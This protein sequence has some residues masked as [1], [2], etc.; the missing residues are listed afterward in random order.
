MAKLFLVKSLSITM[1]VV[2]SQCAQSFPGTR[3]TL[4]FLFILFKSFD[5]I[6]HKVTEHSFKSCA[7]YLQSHWCVEIKYTFSS[8]FKT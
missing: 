3:T 1:C 8:Y 4:C 2:K 6:N 5:M 7:T